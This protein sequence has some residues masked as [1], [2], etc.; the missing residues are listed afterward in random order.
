MK[1][2]SK[3]MDNILL[4]GTCIFGSFQKTLFSF[5]ISF[6][7]IQGFETPLFEPNLRRKSEQLQ[8]YTRYTFVNNNNIINQITLISVA[9]SLFLRSMSI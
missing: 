3:L 6:L 9:I 2:E 8:Y 5:L 4:N 1:T 7:F